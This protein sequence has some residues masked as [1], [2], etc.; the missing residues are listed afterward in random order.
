MRG[1]QR[2]FERE[3]AR[4]TDTRIRGATLERATGGDLAIT[5]RFQSDDAASARPLALGFGHAP[6]FVR[7]GEA[8]GARV[9]ERS[10]RA[11]GGKQCVLEPTDTWERVSVRLRCS[12][13]PGADV[14]RFPA[15][16]PDYEYDRPWHQQPEIDAS[17]FG[18]NVVSAVPSHARNPAAFETG[19]LWSDRLVRI[20]REQ[21]CILAGA[22]DG[23]RA[24]T[25]AFSGERIA[26]FLNGLFASHPCR[27]AAVLVDDYS[28]LVASSVIP[29]AGRRVFPAERRVS[30]MTLIRYWSA[31]WLGCGVR[32]L[33]AKEPPLANGLRAALGALFLRE[34][35]D[36]AR[37]EQAREE[38]AQLEAVGPWFRASLD[39][40]LDAVGVAKLDRFVAQHWGGYV[41]TAALVAELGI[42]Q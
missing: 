1:K 14:L 37:F 16:L 22:R 27:L 9:N 35:G 34:S 39:F 42:S 30:E 36:V 2:G 15:E 32:I 4:S 3:S 24:A 41:E 38:F 13:D 25:L 5:L 28:S 10:L 19:I 26:A 8:V 23:E 31:A 21:V 40:L 11:S 18:A 7:D 17:A 6:F 29:F 20:D 33:H 12:V